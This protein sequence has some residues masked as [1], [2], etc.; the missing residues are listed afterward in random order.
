MHPA[1]IK[2]ARNLRSQV[3][4][5]I[6]AATPSGTHLNL[7]ASGSIVARAL[8]EDQKLFRGILVLVVVAFAIRLAVIP[9]LIGDS[10]NPARAHWTFGWEEGR[11]ARSIASGEGFSS[12][13]FG[14]TGPSAWTGPVYPYLLAGVFRIFGIYTSASAWVILSLNALFSALTCIPICLIARR[15]FGQPAAIW[16]GWIWAFY[17]YAIYFAGGRIWGFCLDTLLMA[18]V[19]WGTIAIEQETSMPRWIGYGLLWGFAALNNAVILATLPFLLGWIIWRRHKHGMAWRL[20]GTVVMVMLVLVVMPSFVRNYRTFGQFI[21]FRSDFWYV[22]WQSNTGD[23]SD[24]Y[25]DWANAAH[26]SS[27][28]E[29]YRKL[30]EIGYMQEKRLASL[31][32]VRR[33]PGLFV[34]LTVKRII[35]TWTGF[36]SLRRDYLA[37]EP[38][39]FPNIA[40]CSVLGLLLIAGVRQ[41]YRINR[42]AVIPL[43]LVLFSYPLVYYI[44]HPGMDYRHPIDPIYAVFIGVL[45]SMW[46][47]HRAEAV[48]ITQP[49]Q[50]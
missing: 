19:I 27:E 45:C 7:P 20:S 26:N 31:E 14:K 46:A 1:S 44:V 21:P 48:A 10:L 32:F 18:L 9:F 12:P 47:K 2:E 49:E 36:W 39:A 24:I 5:W 6:P 42:N 22:F 50:P 13:L 41:A 37:H 23:T 29:K 16:A 35:F 34:W 38:F 33:Y 15:G 40:F 25:P 28:M 30:G 4:C 8:E 43:G 17:P 3:W 11:L